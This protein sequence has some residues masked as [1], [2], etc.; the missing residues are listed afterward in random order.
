MNWFSGVFFAGFLLASA[1]LGPAG[2]AQAT[3][4]SSSNSPLQSTAPSDNTELRRSVS[5]S[6]LTPKRRSANISGAG[7]ARART[8]VASG[9]AR[10]TQVLCFQ[11]G[12][13]WLHA[14][15]AA[16]PLQA[17]TTVKT[18]GDEPAQERSLKIMN[19]QSLAMGR[20]K[21]ESCPADMMGGGLS[22]LTTATIS[23]NEKSALSPT[24]LPATSGQFA[25]LGAQRWLQSNSMLN[26]ASSFSLNRETAYPLSGYTY[27]QRRTSK[28]S[29]E[30]VGVFITQ[31]YVSPIKLRRMIRMMR[32]SPDL[33]TRI[34]LRR[35][36][37]RQTVR[38][39]K[40]E[41]RNARQDCGQRNTQ[42]DQARDQAEDKDKGLDTDREAGIFPCE[43]TPDQ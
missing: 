23:D 39:Q 38:T 8:M 32:N 24:A 25:G 36:E 42:R 33:Q 10:A 13:G 28:V 5:A 21:P 15:G 41:T 11:P 26:P 9:R 43:L 17:V 14:P 7:A 20:S 22:D 19:T 31:A 18:R 6:A 16:G 2:R 1:A 40:S 30:A 35:L 27:A 29:R 3:A 34:Q 12:I 4:D 37:S